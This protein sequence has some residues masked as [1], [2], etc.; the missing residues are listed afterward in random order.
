MNCLNVFVNNEEFSDVA[1]NFPETFFGGG[2]RY[3]DKNRYYLNFRVPQVYLQ[4]K[5]KGYLSGETRRSE[6]EG[7]GFKSKNRQ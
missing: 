7:H 3:R 1:E 5:I 2:D 4:T 6:S